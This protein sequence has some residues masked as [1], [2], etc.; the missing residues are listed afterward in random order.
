MYWLT[1]VKSDLP[2]HRFGRAAQAASAPGHGTASALTE[3]VTP[4]ARP[5]LQRHEVA[6]TAADRGAAFSRELTGE[7]P[8]LLR[9]QVER[10]PSGQFPW[11]W[12]RRVQ[13]HWVPAVIADAPF[14]PGWTCVRTGGFSPTGCLRSSRVLLPDA[15]H[16]Y[17]CK[18]IENS[19]SMVTERHITRITVSRQEPSGQVAGQT[20]ATQN[21]ESAGDDKSRKAPELLRVVSVSSGVLTA[22]ALAL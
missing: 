20:A 21:R 15:L 18:G 4:G 7:P 6:V 11:R 2:R 17:G 10:M 16:R 9:G 5:A 3:R 22:G 12:W 1:T 13:P 8:N 14:L 19:N